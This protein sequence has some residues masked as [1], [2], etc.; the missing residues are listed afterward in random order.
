M[1]NLM[2]LIF[3]TCSYFYIKNSLKTFQ[4]IVYLFICAQ[5]IVIICSPHAF[6][7]TSTGPSCHC[8]EAIEPRKFNR[9]EVV[10]EGFTA[11]PLN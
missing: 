6:D 2:G 3:V 1:S 5:Q 4:N 9:R 8:V 11:F 7:R 10:Q